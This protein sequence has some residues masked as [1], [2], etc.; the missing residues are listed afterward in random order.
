M[1]S[2]IQ[3]RYV[4]TVHSAWEPAR[5]LDYMADFRNAVEW[6]P[7]VRKALLAGKVEDAA[8]H[9]RERGTAFDL[10]VRVGKRESAL[11][12]VI[13]AATATSVELTARTDSIESIDT[14]TVRP[15]ST[16]GSVMEYDAR[17]TFLGLA[18]LANPLL[19]RSLRKLGDNA[20]ARL[21]E[22][23]NA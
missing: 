1:S 6:D 19:A 23:L 21:I 7:S 5:V 10:T 16:G 20:V 8:S 13:T 17:L 22:K 15:D 12:Y 14:I 4:A 18:R 11:R 9:L 2:L 3:P